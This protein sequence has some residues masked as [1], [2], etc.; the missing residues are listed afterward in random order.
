M[1]RLMAILLPLLAAILCLVYQS[2]AQSLPDVRPALNKR[3][4]TSEAINNLIAGLVPYFADP[5]LA[6]LFSNC[7][8]NTLD[9]TVYYHGVA[10][11]GTS[12]LDSFVI[13]GDIEALWLRDSANQVFLHLFSIRIIC[14]EEICYLGDT[15]PSLREHRC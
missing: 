6:Q 12:D 9:T 15:L 4:F 13:T 5:N 3:T 1:S 7:L 2:V 14:V 11:D 10:E 8:P